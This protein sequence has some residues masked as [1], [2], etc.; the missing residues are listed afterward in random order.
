MKGLIINSASVL[1]DFNPAN[2]SSMLKDMGGGKAPGRV[3]KFSKNESK[4]SAHYA[5]GLTPSLLN[6]RLLQHRLLARPARAGA[7]QFRRNFQNSRRKR[8][9]KAK[10]RHQEVLSGGPT[11]RISR[12]RFGEWRALLGGEEHPADV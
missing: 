3:K 4:S 2:I 1:F 9:Q 12:V 8:L 11:A 7:V 10:V 5:G 6:P